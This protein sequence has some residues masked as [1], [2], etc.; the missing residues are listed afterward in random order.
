VTPI[1]QSFNEFCKDVLEFCWAILNPIS[2][3][4]PCYKS[5]EAARGMHREWWYIQV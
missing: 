3:Y 4:F 2:T 1:K 5:L